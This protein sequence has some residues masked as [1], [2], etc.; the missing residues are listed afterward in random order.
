MLL[1]INAV[2]INRL[3]CISKREQRQLTMES[4]ADPAPALASTTSVPAFWILS[5]IFAASS[6]S[7]STSGCVCMHKKRAF[8]EAAA[9][10]I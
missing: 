10:L 8:V 1:V 2:I 6:V 9:I 7:N 4:V 5:V 3:Y